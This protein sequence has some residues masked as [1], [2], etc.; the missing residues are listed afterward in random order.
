MTPL[1]GRIRGHQLCGL[2][3]TEYSQLNW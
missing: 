3:S 2:Y 1:Q